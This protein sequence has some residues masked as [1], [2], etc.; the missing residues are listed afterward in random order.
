V[1]D[2]G[3]AAILVAAVLLPIAVLGAALVVGLG[4]LAAA[5]AALQGAADAAALAAAPATFDAFGGPSDPEVA[6]A[7]MAEANGTVLESCDCRVD[8]T[9]AP[10]VVVVSVER[11]ITVLGPFAATVTARAAAEFAPVDLLR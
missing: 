3:A 8:R 9:W 11:R 6:A 5:R 1:T 7:R 2:R 4:R 10:R